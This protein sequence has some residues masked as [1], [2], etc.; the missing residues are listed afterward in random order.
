MPKEKRANGGLAAGER[1]EAKPFPR[2]WRRL[3]RFSRR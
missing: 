3:C 2:Y 1:R